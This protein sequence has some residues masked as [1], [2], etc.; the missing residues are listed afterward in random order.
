[1][2]AGRDRYR[3]S[4]TAVVALGLS[5]TNLVLRKPGSID[6]STGSHKKD[7]SGHRAHS[8]LEKSANG[9]RVVRSNDSYRFLPTLRQSNRRDICHSFLLEDLASRHPVKASLRLAALGLDRVPS[10]CPSDSET[11]EWRNLEGIQTTLTFFA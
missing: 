5:E 11:K 2:G 7:P 4:V 3:T 6:G 9:S 8:M 10:R 1:M